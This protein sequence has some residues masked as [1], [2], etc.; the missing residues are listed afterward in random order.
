M[1]SATENSSNYK[2]KIPISVI[3]KNQ[4]KLYL[5]L[6]PVYITILGMIFSFPL[7]IW[8]SW[9]IAWKTFLTSLFLF[10]V[11]NGINNL[12]KKSFKAWKEYLI[13]ADK[14]D[15]TK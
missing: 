2:E 4:K 12:F 7:W 5:Y 10:L 11:T 9:E 15:Y 6:Y 8:F 14:I 13:K 1:K 3:N